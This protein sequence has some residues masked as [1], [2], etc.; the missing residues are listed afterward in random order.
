[1]SCRGQIPPNQSI[2]NTNIQ[3]QN[4]DTELNKNEQIENSVTLLEKSCVE[5]P[6]ENSEIS[7]ENS[8]GELPDIDNIPRQCDKADQEMYNFPTD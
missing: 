6:D 2:K 5:L 4:K 7:L 1:M 3:V 8:F